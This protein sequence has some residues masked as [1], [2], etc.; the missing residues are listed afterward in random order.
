MGKEYN[1]CRDKVLVGYRSGLTLDANDSNL[2]HFYINILV[3][4][5]PI[6]FAKIFH[7]KEVR[8]VT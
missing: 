1:V 7:D 3:T 6:M 2:P 5:P 8:V 4:L